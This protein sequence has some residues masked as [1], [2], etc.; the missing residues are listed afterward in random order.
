ML[1]ETAGKQSRRHRPIVVFGSGGS[2]TRAVAQFLIDCRVS[3]GD[4][5]NDSND[6]L[7]IT[8]IINEH[9][10]AILEATRCLNYDPK[11]IDPAV[12]SAVVSEYRRAGRRHRQGPVERWGFKEPRNMFMLPLIDLAFPAALFVHVVR[13]GRD[14]LL[15]NNHNQPRKYFEALFGRAFERTQKGIA[16]FWAKTN[17]EARAFAL[18][19]FNDRYIVARIEDLCG[20]EKHEHVKR[21]SEALDLDG[22]LAGRAASVFEMQP[23]FGRGRLHCFESALTEDFRDAL[24]KFHYA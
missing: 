14:M 11:A 18:E 12:C 13:D 5:K 9:A 21:L 24:A 23:S 22:D 15:A 4:V 3:M 20:P 16:R 10:N 17:M 8:E 19:R 6:A 1:N 7:R 2:G